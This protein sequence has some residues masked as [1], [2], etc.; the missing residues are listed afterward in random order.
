LSQL[1]EQD[2]EASL[3]QI[4][5]KEKS[6]KIISAIS[7]RIKARDEKEDLDEEEEEEGPTDRDKVV[8]SAFQTEMCEVP[9][10]EEIMDDDEDLV[11]WRSNIVRNNEIDCSVGKSNFKNSI[12]LNS[13]SRGNVKSLQSYNNNS[14]QRGQK[15][16]QN[17][18][19]ER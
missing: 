4:E 15:K 2:V 19:T 10:N 1:D 5:A 13:Q 9:D 16:Q 3:S 18:I 8:E 17:G 6:I 11:D 12:F 7:E 14:S